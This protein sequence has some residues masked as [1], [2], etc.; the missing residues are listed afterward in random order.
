M[1]TFCLFCA[2][3]VEAQKRIIEI[4]NNDR[5]VRVRKGL[6]V[7]K[8]DFLKALK[9][10]YRL[11]QK[12]DFKDNIFHRGELSDKQEKQI[13]S[14]FSPK[15]FNTLIG[16]PPTK[17]ADNQFNYIVFVTG[18]KILTQWPK[19]FYMLLDKLYDIDSCKESQTVNR[20]FGMLQKTHML[21]VNDAPEFMRNSYYKWIKS[22]SKESDYFFSKDFHSDAHLYRYSDIIYGINKSD[23]N[24][25]IPIYLSDDKWEKIKRY[26]PLPDTLVGNGNIYNKAVN[27]CR[28]FASA[29]MYKL[30]TGCAWSSVP[31]VKNGLIKPG[32][33]EQRVSK[34]RKAALLHPLT[35]SL[36]AM[37]NDKFE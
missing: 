28:L 22:K 26:F 29:Y 19:M 10:L 6:D 5:L 21:I 16:Q 25:N 36:I 3:D 24:L 27:S 34:L 4:I 8:Y 37:S 9:I 20:V 32:G 1:F 11:L 31:A 30:I 35:K 7:D 33:L 15:R 2:N 17:I 14:Y 12:I 18:F 23:H 13:S